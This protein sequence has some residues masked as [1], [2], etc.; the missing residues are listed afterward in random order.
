MRYE[1]LIAAAQ[2]V[3]P[4]SNGVCFLPQLRGGDQ[5]Y[6]SPHA[7]AAFVGIAGDS[8]QGAL[9]RSVLEGVAMSRTARRR[10]HDGH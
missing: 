5:P 9:F 2:K 3:P 8:T 6:P 1:A 10:G 7:R 4:G